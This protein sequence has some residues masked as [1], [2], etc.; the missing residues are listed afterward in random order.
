MAMPGIPNP[1]G[2][3][4]SG[5]D[6][7]TDDAGDQ[8]PPDRDGEVDAGPVDPGN[9][10]SA[11]Q[12][13]Y[14]MRVDYY[15]TAVASEGGNTLRVKNR[16]SNLFITT[17]TAG[18]GE[19]RAVE[20][21]CVQGSAHQCQ[22]A[23][24][25]DWTTTYDADLPPLYAANSKV[26]R[27]WSVDAASRKLTVKAS[28]ALLALGF[29]PSQG[30]ELP[31]SIA[32]ANVWQAGS[33]Q[34]AVQRGLHT[35]VSATLVAGI[36]APF[37]CNINSVLLFGTAFEGTLQS[38]DAVGLNAFRAAVD[39]AGTRASVLAASDASGNSLT[40]GYC[41]PSQLQS[42]MSAD[43]KVFVSFKN[44]SANTACPA[45]ATDYDK[46][47]PPASELDPPTL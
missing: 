11:L 23:S 8:V 12:G 13:R 18:Q 40:A 5:E 47:F 1:C 19:L 37:R 24:C 34:A 43:D 42:S 15:S 41:T 26:E 29:Y 10:L 17:L 9:P 33:T 28:G 27:A 7:I 38:L 16:I 25:T 31:T 20:Q 30:F 22:T 35:F 36:S 45:K 4:D 3:P 14:L 2:E 6:V 32:D 46:L 21:L 39:P 44:T